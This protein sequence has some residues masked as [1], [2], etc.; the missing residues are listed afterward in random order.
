MKTKHYM[1]EIIRTYVILA[2]FQGGTYIEQVQA[3]SV[4]DALIEWRNKC[5]LENAGKGLTSIPMES[6]LEFVHE[7]PP[8]LLDNLK[9][10]WYTLL[11][12]DNEI[13][14]INIVGQQIQEHS[15][16]S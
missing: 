1:N 6:F 14:H 2:E 9:D 16:S 3:K 7:V 15:R 13:I 10:V 12:F 5:P 4:N 11:N 8:T